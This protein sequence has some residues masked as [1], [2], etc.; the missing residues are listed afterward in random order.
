MDVQCQGLCYFGLFVGPFDLSENTVNR[1]IIFQ[2]DAFDVNCS[3]VLS[4]V[5]SPFDKEYFFLYCLISIFFYEAKIA[6]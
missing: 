3:L 2:G 1:H 5:K 4:N 6:S